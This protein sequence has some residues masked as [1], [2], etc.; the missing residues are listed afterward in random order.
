MPGLYLRYVPPRL[1]NEHA[2]MFISLDCSGLYFQ[3]M[4]GVPRKCESELLHF[5]HDLGL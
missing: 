5:T 3:Y 2:S 4:P 1:G